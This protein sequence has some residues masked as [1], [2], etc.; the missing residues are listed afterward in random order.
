MSTTKNGGWMTIGKII[1]VVILST[2][3]LK[4][5]FS[6]ERSSSDERRSV[7]KLRTRRLETISSWRKEYEQRLEQERFLE[8]TNLLYD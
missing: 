7:K 1:T 8:L 2:I 6:K 4:T 5:S 3:I